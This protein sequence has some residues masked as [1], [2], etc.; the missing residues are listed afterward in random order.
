MADSLLYGLAFWAPLSLLIFFA[1][2]L[3]GEV[4]TVSPKNFLWFLPTESYGWGLFLL[5]I[6]VATYLSGV[7]MR[8]TAVRRQL[9][10]IPV[11]GPFFFGGEI[12]T[13]DRL[14]NLRPCLFMASPTRL[15]YGWLLSEEKV[16]VNQRAA[17]FTVL[18]VYRPSIPLFIAGQLAPVRK[19]AVM[20]LGN[21]S[22]E[23]VDVMLYTLR[24]PDALLFLPWPDETPDEFRARADKFGLLTRSKSKKP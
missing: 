22:R 12:M 7:V 11:V 8:L 15:S 18:N 19:S 1:L 16:S 24:C 5:G 4:E 13:P 14:T 3:L 9:A 21:S 20:R 10:R 2:L 23:I 6:V 17:D